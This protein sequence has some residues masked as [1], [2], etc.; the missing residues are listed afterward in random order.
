MVELIAGQNGELSSEKLIFTVHPAQPRVAA[1]ILNAERRPL[2]SGGYLDA[3]GSPRHRG[4][5]I[6]SDALHISLDAVAADVARILC[7]ATELDPHTAVLRCTLTDDRG[8][9][10]AY[11]IASS[12]LH[13][14][15]ICFELYRRGP[16]WKVRAVGQGYAGGIEE[17]LRAH[18]VSDITVRQKVEP[19]SRTPAASQPST[20][21]H[22]ATTVP[23]TP[24]GGQDPLQRIAMIYEDAA[25]SSSALLTAHRF[26]EDRRDSEMSAAV[27][28][29]STR[30]G[31][32]SR[33]ALERAQRRHD[34]LIA[35]ASADYRRD[36][37]HLNAELSALDGELPCALASWTAPA[38]QHPPQPAN[39]IRLGSLTMSD[40][41]P[42]T[43]PL[44]VA[45]PI[46]RP[47]WIDSPNTAAALPVVASVLVRLLAAVP[48]AQPRLDVI[49]LA[50]AVGPL[51]RQ[52]QDYMPRPAVNSHLAVLGRLQTLTTECDLAALQRNSAAPPPVERIL[53]IT[54]L[55]YGFPSEA[56]HA[57]AQVINHS[58]P[59]GLAL[60]V[61]GDHSDA[62]SSTMPLLREIANYS[63]H[64]RLDTDDARLLDPWTHNA[65]RFQ[66]DTL[67]PG[68]QLTQLIATAARHRRPPS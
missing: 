65:W 32:T 54:D 45:L 17:M 26:A 47:L 21:P 58:V 8:Q 37:A 64:V 52:L 1:L 24:L 2:P 50:G 23:I 5:T 6:E 43:V 11:T 60:L 13:P 7:V 55:G 10:T 34:E 36:A 20:T 53:V 4:I 9:L 19:P 27:A 40:A 68:V 31:D 15:L 48:C 61:V 39:G 30:N 67:S 41:G 63:H 29:S 66:P 51:L 14:A 57:T 18:G 33:Q 56:I 22:G 38:W 16:R 42:L 25:R 62:A 3:V 59:A 12:D 44:C 46:Q 35:A 28:D 49:D